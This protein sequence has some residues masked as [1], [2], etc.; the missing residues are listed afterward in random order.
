MD[1]AW[2]E[3]R[4]GPL[5]QEGRLVGL[6]HCARNVTE[7][8]QALEA[9]MRSEA[10]WR[11]LVDN[12]PAFVWRLDNDGTVRFANRSLHHGSPEEVGGA[13]VL[14][15]VVSKQ[16]AKVRSTLDRIA[17]T[18]TPETFDVQGYGD[19][20]RV[21]WWRTHIGPVIQ[22]GSADGLIAL[23]WIVTAEK[24]AEADLRRSRRRLEALSRRLLSV[25]EEERRHVA[26]EIHD[27]LG[28]DLTALKMDLDWIL[29]NAGPGQDKTLAR[30]QS[31]IRLA[32]STIGKVRELA[33][34]LRPA[35]LDDLGLVP[36]LEGQLQ[37][38]HSYSGVRC[39]AEFSP[40]DI[41]LD[42]DTALTV[43]RVFQESLT[44]VARHARATR[45]RV[46]LRVRGDILKLSIEDN[47]RGITRRERTSPRSL[48]LIGIRER[49]KSCHGRVRIR[50]SA[51]MGTAVEI[52]VPVHVRG[53]K[54]KR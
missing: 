5:V 41:D 54:G 15:Y 16:H 39:V 1:P 9:L 25:Q 6:I 32:D 40:Q 18:G 46:T 30:V 10:V 48:G 49:V 11:S 13:S 23:A 43:F 22:E 34:T 28:Q 2:H 29:R 7:R 20:G 19:G 44:N 8:K 17:R 3:V 12:A 47:G 14:D 21:V 4:V 27:E 33:R 36:A 51:K 37:E 31:A 38:F 35:A 24:Q 52:T 45:V 53:I 26:R 42:P 50:G